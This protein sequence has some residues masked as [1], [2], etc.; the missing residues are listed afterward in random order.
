MDVL[1]S[2]ELTSTNRSCGLIMSLRQTSMPR[3]SEAARTQDSGCE[4]SRFVRELR[5]RNRTIT[6]VRN[7]KVSGGDFEE[8]T[9]DPIPNSEVKLFG[10]DGTAREAVWESRTLPGLSLKS[11]SCPPRVGG[12]GFLL[13]W[14]VTFW[15]SSGLALHGTRSGSMV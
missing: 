10:A 14:P 2:T 1:Q 6:I 9:P 4:E 11:L 8:A 15:L 5:T 12:S 7:P 3:S 13:L